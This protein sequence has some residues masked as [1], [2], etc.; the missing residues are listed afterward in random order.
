MLVRLH[1]ILQRHKGP[2]PAFLH[3]ISPEIPEEILAL[4]SHLYL[5]PSEAL[6]EEINQLFNYPVLD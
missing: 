2:I 3:F 1:T 4:P 5:R 6:K